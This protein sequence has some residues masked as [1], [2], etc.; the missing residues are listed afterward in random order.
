[1]KDTNFELER[2]TEADAFDARYQKALHSIEM[3][4][5]RKE[6]QSYGMMTLATAMAG[7]YEEK[8]RPGK[9][10]VFAR[11]FCILFAFLVPSLLLIRVVL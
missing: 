9:A 8:Y 11:N 1:M 3:E 10:V 2:I 5:K 6:M 4:K 7:G